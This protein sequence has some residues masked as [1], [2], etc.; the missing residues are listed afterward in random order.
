M[1]TAPWLQHGEELREPD[2]VL[3]QMVAR[4][5]A[6]ADP[7][8][9][10]IVALLSDAALTVRQV[11]AALEMSNS[12]AS[13]HLKKLRDAGLV[14]LTIDA[15]AHRH[16][17]DEAALEELQQT[18]IGRV[19]LAAVAAQV[20]VAPYTRRVVKAFT[21]DHGRVNRLPREPRRRK[22]VA[23]YLAEALGKDFAFTER[24][25]SASLDALTAPPLSREEALG[26]LMRHAYLRPDHEAGQYYF[27]IASLS[28]P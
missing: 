25:L 6:L 22:I 24:T 4:F 15:Y 2:E 28:G 26:A 23:E 20:D 19:E 17:V 14:A 7:T 18:F 3:D 21:D 13:R 9:L 8:R 11:A 1:F 16:S 27:A 5:A 10:R 12:T